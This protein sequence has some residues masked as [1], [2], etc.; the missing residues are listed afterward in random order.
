MAIKSIII[1]LKKK[2]LILKGILGELPAKDGDGCA[3]GC[4]PGF[5][6][7]CV[8]SA[9][10]QRHRQPSAAGLNASPKDVLL[11]VLNVDA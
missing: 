6:K 4:Q 9:H 3:Q 10:T 2:I 7:A 5:P 8:P 11:R 1:L